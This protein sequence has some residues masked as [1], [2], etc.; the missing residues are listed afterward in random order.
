MSSL[1]ALHFV[2]HQTGLTHQQI[3]LAHF[4]RL[5]LLACYSAW[6]IGLF[7]QLVLMA[8]FIGLIYWLVLSACFIGSFYRLGFLGRYYRLVLSAWKNEPII[9]AWKTRPINRPV[10]SASAW[11]SACRWIAPKGQYSK[12][13]TVKGFQYSFWKKL[14]SK[15]GRQYSFLRALRVF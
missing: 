7:Y 13:G 6:F 8:W 11:L 15:K 4:Y 3:I 1:G 10:L 12:F 9:S 2:G 5:L 14:G